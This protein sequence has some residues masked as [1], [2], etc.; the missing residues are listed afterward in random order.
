MFETLTVP[1]WNDFHPILVHFPI[2][3]LLLAPILIIF[4]TFSK[5]RS[6]EWQFFSTAIIGLGTIFLLLSMSTGELAEARAEQFPGA[7]PVL[8]AHESL[9][10]STRNLFLGMLT[11]LSLLCVAGVKF[12]DRLTAKVR[13]TTGLTLL[14]IY[15]VPMSLLI[16]T[17][18]EGARLV[19]EIGVRAWSPEEK[20]D[21]GQLEAPEI[22]KTALEAPQMSDTG[23]REYKGL[24][25]VVAYS[26]GI[27][28]GS[29]PHGEA[30][31][32][33]L[34]QLGVQTVISV[35][36]AKPEIAKAKRFGLRYVH[37]PIG[38]NGMNEARKLE[39]A[40]VVQDLPH[41]VYIHCH[42]GKHRSAAAT[43]SALV[44]LGFISPREAVS[45][46]KVSG[47]S[48][49]YRGLYSV[50]QNSK[51]ASYFQL[52]AA[53]HSFP[54]LAKTTGL[55]Q[56]MV[57]IDVVKDRLKL[58]EKSAWKTTSHHPDLIPAAEA[59]KLADLLRNL[60]DNE[61]VQSKG[62]EFL[63]LM[64]RNANEAQSLERAFT[65][66]LSKQEITK[67]WKITL[68]SCTECHKDY[69]NE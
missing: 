7:G 44:T 48:A 25:N 57:E 36:G 46:M 16:R 54:E 42:H 3:L 31:F 27:Y 26:K 45:R 59:G 30:G 38:Y 35:D 60:K 2:A 50:V 22:S 51:P 67:R 68:Q 13:V 29:V 4:A 43:G 19:H 15:L 21:L 65:Q 37:L 53:G 62:E 49:H 17:S 39:I 34:K 11:L 58:L 10:H 8:E 61:R 24:H 6:L 18:H 12:K 28:S 14:I 20:D 52:Q 56:T 64:L 55:V 9:A 32:F 47:T 66:G 41:P 40:R 69:R 23:P 1:A 63:Q 5:K 33:A